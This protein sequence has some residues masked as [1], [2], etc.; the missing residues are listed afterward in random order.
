MASFANAAVLCCV[1]EDRRAFLKNVICLLL[2]VM[3]ATAMFASGHG[4]TA[5][6]CTVV[7]MVAFFVMV[8]FT[9]IYEDNDTLF[10]WMTRT[11]MFYLGHVSTFVVYGII[12]YANQ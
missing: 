11:L 4:L 10:H 5:A 7:L 8:V 12:V 2:S 1:Q 6:A 9:A 3:L